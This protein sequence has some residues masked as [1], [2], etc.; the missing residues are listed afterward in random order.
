MGWLAPSSVH[1]ALPNLVV[2]GQSATFECVRS[3]NLESRHTHLHR[4]MGTAD[5]R[6]YYGVT[7]YGLDNIVKQSYWGYFSIA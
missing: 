6:D 4:L 1:L 5:G 2:L 3:N 7:Y